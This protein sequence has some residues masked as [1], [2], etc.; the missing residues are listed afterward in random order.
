LSPVSAGSGFRLARIA[1]LKLC[2]SEPPPKSEI[3]N[4]AVQ[5][6]PPF[7]DHQDKDVG[8]LTV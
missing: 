5:P 8:V 2:S 4:Q 6:F 1:I 7:L 3:F